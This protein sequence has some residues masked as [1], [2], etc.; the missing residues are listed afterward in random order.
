MLFYLHLKNNKKV[1]ILLKYH[2]KVTMKTNLEIATNNNENVLNFIMTSILTKY[3]ISN[4]TFIKYKSS[5]T[6]KHCKIK[7]TIIDLKLELIHSCEMNAV[8][9]YFLASVKE[10]Y[11]IGINW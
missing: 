2:K 1:R 3:H 9:I 8:F 4:T 7:F 5:N 11:P 10:E 6:D